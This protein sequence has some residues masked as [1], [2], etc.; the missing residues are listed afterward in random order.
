MT[1]AVQIVFMWPESE[2]RY[3]WANIDH[4]EPMQ[5]IQPLH[6]IMAQAHLHLPHEHME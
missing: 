1:G 5:N 6:F 4:S 3:L 2:L